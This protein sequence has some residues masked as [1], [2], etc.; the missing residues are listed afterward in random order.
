VGAFSIADLK[1]TVT[2]EGETPEGFASVGRGR[3]YEVSGPGG[4]RLTVRD[5]RWDN[6]ERDVV[7]SE[8]HDSPQRFDTLVERLRLPVAQRGGDLYA[9]LRHVRLKPNGRGNLFAPS[10]KELD[11]GAGVQVARELRRHGALRVGTREDLLG[12]EGRTRGRLGMRVPH[13]AEVLPVIAY[14]LTR[15]GPVAEGIVA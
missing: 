7:A 3:L 14:V 5:T 15:V 2:V 1:R 11:G 13:D 8:R 6:G 12:D 4:L 9:E 10:E